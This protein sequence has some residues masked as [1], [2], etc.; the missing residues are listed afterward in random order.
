MPCYILY[1]THP[2]KHT[3]LVGL[4]CHCYPS[5]MCYE[6]NLVPKFPLTLLHVYS[7]I[8]HLLHNS[9][10]VSLSSCTGACYVGWS[11][12]GIEGYYGP[13]VTVYESGY[14]VTISNTRFLLQHRCVCY[15]AD[16]STPCQPPNPHPTLFIHGAQ[17]YVPCFIL[18]FLAIFTFYQV[19]RLATLLR[20]SHNASVLSPAELTTSFFFPIHALFYCMHFIIFTNMMY[21]VSSIIT[22]I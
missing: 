3:L 13:Q 19:Y 16:I 4:S 10:H 11:E 22:Y 21:G 17:F 20:L 2:P 12:G 14:A 5:S 15:I 18:S 9:T 6:K 7:V 8:V 1:N